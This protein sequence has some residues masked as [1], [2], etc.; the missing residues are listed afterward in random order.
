MC[1]AV[2]GPWLPNRLARCCPSGR[3]NTGMPTSSTLTGLAP[4]IDAHTRILVLGSFP[5]AVSL[6][7]GQY[8]AHPRN[9]FWPLMAAVTNEPLADMAYEERLARLLAHGIGVW[10]TIAACQR[11]G[12]LD[13]AIRQAQANELSVLRERSPQLLRV[14]FNGKTSGKS[15]HHF[16]TAGYDTLVLPSSSPAYAQ[17]SFDA[18]LAI[19]KKIVDPRR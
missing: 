17:M 16:S 8:Y 5:G 7:A 12:S 14:C 19:W 18:K 15:E 9:Q 13:A 3:Y 2:R 6:E 10:D 1:A 11:Q 4:V